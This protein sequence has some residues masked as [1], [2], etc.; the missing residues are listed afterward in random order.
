MDVSK[1]SK[2]IGY[3]RQVIDDDDVAAVVAALRS[4]FLTQGEV[5]PR[6]E[7]ALAERV[8]ARYAVAVSNGTAALHVACLAAGLQP[9][10]RG[11]TSAITF[12]ASANCIRYCG[13]DASVVD[14][15]PV[16]LG[17]SPVALGAYLANA[18]ATSIV[19]PVHVAGLSGGMSEIRAAAGAR[20]IIED[21]AHALG[22]ADEDGHPVGSCAHSDM[23]TFSFHP[24]KTITT[25]EGGAVTTN[26]PELYRRLLLFRNHGL[27]REPDRML[28]RAEAGSPWYY[29]QQVMGF[30]YR[31]TDVQAALGLSQLTKLDRFL[32]RRREVAMTYD[33]AFAGMNRL[34]PLQMGGRHRSGMHLY[35]VEIDFASLGKTRGAVMAELRARGVGSQVHYI[36]VHHQPV[37]KSAASDECPAA[38]R[39]YERCLSLPLHAAMTDDDVAVV[40]KAVREVLGDIA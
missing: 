3:G 31:L 10:D 27:E 12:V 11:V 18:P 28:D 21:G 17:M 33:G 20:T 25:G 36:P 2:V 26:D 24:V 22:G 5:V 9:G 34:R 4:D 29:E 1:V 32:A 15:D 13:A 30:N 8:G 39:Y 38:E 19:V 23:T 37:H 40:I 16:G 7:A 6:F 14:I 35:L